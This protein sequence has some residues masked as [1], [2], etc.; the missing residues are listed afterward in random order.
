MTRG[1]FVASLRGCGG[2]VARYRPMLMHIQF[3]LFVAGFSFYVLGR[4]GSDV[5]DAETWGRL[6]YI[7]P[8]WF[9]G[10][11]NMLASAICIIGLIN[12]PHKL[13]ILVGLALH[14]VQ[15][16][17]MSISCFFFGGDETLGGWGLAFLM[18]HAIAFVKSAQEW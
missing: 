11:Y 1:E 5:Y 3:S 13:T 14:V 10:A 16:C 12:P 17:A 8:L 15:F 9:W 2:Y 18:F 4:L 6:L 7:H